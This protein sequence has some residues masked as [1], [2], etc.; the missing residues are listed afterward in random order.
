MGSNMQRPWQDPLPLRACDL[1]D[2]GIT[3]GAVRHC[4]CTNVVLARQLPE[5]V[6]VQLPRAKGG[7]CGT[8][9]THM[10]T[11]WLQPA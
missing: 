7:A 11:T 10:R 3:V 5:G 4:V 1:C 9:A 6:P 2:H 8:E